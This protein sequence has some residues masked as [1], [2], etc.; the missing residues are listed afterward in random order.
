MSSNKKPSAHSDQRP[1]VA[2]LG[3]DGRAARRDAFPPSARHF[4]ARRYAGNGP[5]R[6]LTQALRAGSFDRVFIL[7]RW[8]SHAT[9]RR[10][11]RLCR[12]LGVAVEVIP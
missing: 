4:P 9:T 11:L 3:G 8:N 12:Q 10:V 1:R 2:V 5:L 7:A 6:S